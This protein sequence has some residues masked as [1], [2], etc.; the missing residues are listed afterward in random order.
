M[1]SLEQIREELKDVRYYYQRKEIF[2]QNAKTVGMSSIKSKAD[3]YNALVVEA[4]PKLYDVYIGLYVQ[5]NT[6]EGYSLEVGYSPKYIQ[7]LHSE[8]LKF[9]QNKLKEV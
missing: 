6:Q 8:L 2:E 5:G 7:K 1:V 4:P 3:K 9:F